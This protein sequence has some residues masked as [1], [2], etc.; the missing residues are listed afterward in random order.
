MIQGVGFNILQ[1]A[2]WLIHWAWHVR[3]AYMLMPQRSAAEGC[4]SCACGAPCT[5]G[6][7][8]ACEEACK[9]LH[10]PHAHASAHLLA[11]S[12]CRVNTMAALST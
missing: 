7:M 6:P 1:S 9:P 2:R 3:S 5:R 12:P 10:A 4:G 11:R 8:H